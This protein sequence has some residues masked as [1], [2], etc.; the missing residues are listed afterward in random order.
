MR[1][2]AE[3]KAETRERLLASSGAITKQ[4]GFAVTGVDTLMKSVGLTGAAFYS[5]FPSKDALFVELVERE[6]R[7]SLERLGGEPGENGRDKLQR[8]LAAY[9]SLAHV[10]H[11]E[12]GCVLPAL[13]AEIARADESVR[14]QT[15]RQIL[16][17]QTAWAEILDDEKLAW[18]IL[19]Q[20]LGGL[21]LARM[22][23]SQDT[24]QQVLDASLDMLEHTL[25]PVSQAQMPLP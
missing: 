11:P 6:L 24:R 25:K 23:A 7:H 22:M 14:Q 9:L 17:L 2:S 3:H 20:C 1:Y 21:L 5:H 13:G 15:E 10:E 4:Q 16:Q 19:A 18:T 12:K 8:C